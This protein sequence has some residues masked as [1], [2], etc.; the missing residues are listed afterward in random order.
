V[1]Q[2]RPSK[3]PGSVVWRRVTTADELRILPDGCMDLIW[4][5]GSTLLVAGPDTRVHLVSGPPGR[6]MIGIRFATGFG[7]NVLGVPAHELTNQRVQLEAIWPAAEVR[8]MQDRLASSSDPDA[9]LEAM[10]IDAHRADHRGPAIAE[11]VRQLRAGI[12][13]RRVAT[14]LG[15]SE[16]Q[17]RR[18]SLD[19]FGYGPKTLA[20]I[21][22]LNEAIDLART[23]L[24]F[25]DVAAD[26]GY[27]D[28][29][30]LARDVRAFAGVPLSRLM[31]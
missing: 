23:G 20:R 11:M 19:L 5:P 31:G 7:P 9:V 4:V 14:A 12:P 21:L 25:A 15:I 1:Y 18:H 28:Q 24:R 2:E 6:T 8:R 22:R 13:I 27:A 29:A 3:L 17:I 16:R 26:A 30:H 10:A